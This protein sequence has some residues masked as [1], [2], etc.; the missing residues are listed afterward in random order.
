MNPLETNHKIAT[1]WIGYIN[2]N[3]G[4]NI[5]ACFKISNNHEMKSLMVRFHKNDEW[6]I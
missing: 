4:P 6:K 3:V 2:P 5:L 1:S